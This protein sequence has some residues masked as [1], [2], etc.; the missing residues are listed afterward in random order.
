MTAQAIVKDFAMSAE[1]SFHRENLHS[2]ML[3][4][5]LYTDC[6]DKEFRDSIIHTYRSLCDVINDVEKLKEQSV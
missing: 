4:F 5:F 6:P 3:S 1:M 2:M